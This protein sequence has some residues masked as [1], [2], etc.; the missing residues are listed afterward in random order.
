MIQKCL[1]SS[2][3]PCLTVPTGQEHGEEGHLVRS[4]AVA[5]R[6]S[7]GQRVQRLALVPLLAE[8]GD[9]S[10]PHEDVPLR[11][12]SSALLRLRY[13]ST[14]ELLAKTLSVT[15]DLAMTRCTPVLQR[16]HSY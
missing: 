5:P 3:P 11:R 14:S 6:A 8:P 9:K 7:S 12:A 13:V 4:E 15:P 10:C 1:R 2:S 16:G